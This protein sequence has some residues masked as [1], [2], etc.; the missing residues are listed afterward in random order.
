[1]ETH[2][3]HRRRPRSFELW[4][5]HF[6]GHALNRHLAF[7]AQFLSWQEKSPRQQWASLIMTTRSFEWQKLTVMCP[8]STATWWQHWHHLC[9]VCWCCPGQPRGCHFSRRVC[10]LHGQQE[11]YFW[12]WREVQLDRLEE[13]AA[14]ALLF[15][16]LCRRQI[17][18]PGLPIDRDAS[19]Q[20]RYPP[21]HVVD[22]KAPYDLLVKDEHW[23]WPL[24]CIGNAG[25]TR[26]AT[27][28]QS[29]DQMGEFWE[30][31]CRWHDEAWCSATFRR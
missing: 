12:R 10:S 15:A 31:I 20:L 2:L 1:M 29:S 4:L 22:A 9:V 30:A 13:L 24:H 3:W 6:S 7:N 27:S 14:D 28:L 21:A 5:D 18:N 23:Q 25:S 16:C 26:Q 11:C 17:L 8:C 19:A